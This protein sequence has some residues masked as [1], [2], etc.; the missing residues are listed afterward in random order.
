MT[1]KVPVPENEA[2]RLEK[3]DEYNIMDSAPEIVFDEITELAAEILQCP[4]S[5]IQFMDED[6]QWFKSKYGLPDDFVETPRDASICATTICQNPGGL[7][8][9]LKRCKFIKPNL[10]FKDAT[11][12]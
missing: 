7:Y 10:A 4:V 8:I 6:R 3:L 5:F 9:I 12:D 2:E 11:L 1:D